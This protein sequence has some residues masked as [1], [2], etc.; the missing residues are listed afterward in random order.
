MCECA[1]TGKSQRGAAG[2]GDFFTFFWGGKAGMVDFVCVC[3]CLTHPFAD[4]N[5]LLGHGLGIRHVMLHDGLKQLVLVLA[6]KWRLEGTNGG[7]F[8]LK[9]FYFCVNCS[10]SKKINK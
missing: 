6:V 7:Y 3:V 8:P 5:G 1:K 4:R 10:Q 2:E 9:S